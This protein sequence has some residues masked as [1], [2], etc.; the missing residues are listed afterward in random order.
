[1]PTPDS[2][3]S[4]LVV[5]GPEPCPPAPGPP[6]PATRES[7]GCHTTRAVSTRTGGQLPR[8]GRAQALAGAAPDLV[9]PTLRRAGCPWLRHGA[10]AQRGPRGARLGCICP[11]GG[12][13]EPWALGRGGGG[14]C[15]GAGPGGPGRGIPWFCPSSRRLPKPSFGRRPLHGHLGL[16]FGCKSFTQE[17]GGG[18]LP[19][20]SSNAMPLSPPAVRKLDIG[21]VSGFLLLGPRVVLLRSASALGK[22]LG[23]VGGPFTDPALLC[24]VLTHESQTWGFG[25]CSRDVAGLRRRPPGGLCKYVFSRKGISPQFEKEHGPKPPRGGGS[26]R[27][28]RP[29]LTAPHPEPLRVAL[30]FHAHCVQGGAGAGGWPRGVCW[31]SPFPGSSCRRRGR[32]TRVGTP[33]CSLRGLFTY[34]KLLNPV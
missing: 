16:G 7:Q 33:L 14:T 9:G 1:M 25:T 24:T 6:G 4:L 28:P 3:S 13:S 2:R 12:A 31:M 20:S 23:R 15:A 19:E 29:A 11:P 21:V 34:N 17:V 8:A 22:T 10:G 27:S 32:R 30:P 18:G 5:R 26:P